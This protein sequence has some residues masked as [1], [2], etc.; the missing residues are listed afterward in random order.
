MVTGVLVP[1]ASW[2]HVVCVVVVVVVVL[3]L[4]VWG[5]VS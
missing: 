3:V 4:V 5:H 2:L 1:L